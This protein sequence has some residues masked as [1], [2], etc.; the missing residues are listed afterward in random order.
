LF[1]ISKAIEGVAEVRID[2]AD[3]DLNVMD[4][5]AVAE[6]E[7]VIETLAADDTVRA[8]LVTSAKKTFVAGGDLR[9]I[10]AAESLEAARALVERN[11]ACLRR[12][13]TMGKP[14]IALINGLALG[15]GL[16]LAL[17]CTYRIAADSP[18]VKL[19]LPEVGL[20]LMPGA[21]GTVKPAYLIG[22][23][24]AVKLALGGRPIPAREALALGL[25]DEVA[26]A[27]ELVAAALAALDKGTVPSTQPWD[28]QAFDGVLPDPE[29]E[30]GRAVLGKFL[31]AVTGRAAQN[32]P[33]PAAIVAAM[34]EGL[35]TDMDAALL[36][37]QDHFARIVVGP[38]AKA[39][40]RTT[41]FGVNAAKS[42]SMRPRG[43]PAYAIKR[44]GVLGAGQMGA[45]I[46]HVS[47]QARF[48]VAL[49]DISV[50]AAEKGKA[51]IARNCENAVSKGR[52]SRDAAD[53]LLAR[54]TPVTDYDAL[55]GADIIVE[56]VSE[57]EKVKHKVLAMAAEK[58]RPGAPLASNTSTLPITGLAAASPRPEDVIGLHFFAPVDRMPFVEVIRGD[59]TSDQTLARA[60]D[61]IKALRKAV[62]VVRDTLGFYTSRVVAAYTGEAMTLLAEG[63]DPALVDKTALAAGMPLGPLTMCDITSLTLLQDLF[64]SV[65]GDGTRAGVQGLRAKEA[66]ARLVNDFG[67][68]GRASGAGIYDY[69]EGKLTP[70]PG[71]AEAF[72][73]REPPLTP[74]VIE[75]RLMYAQSL[76][77]ARL[78]EQGIVAT[79]T[80]A[81]VGSILGW[82][83]PS[84]TGG[85]ASYIDMVGA[86]KFVADCEALEAEFGG[87]FAVPQ[88]VRDAAASGARFN[89]A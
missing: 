72:P 86:A 58:L 20:G 27:G 18:A 74:E 65:S 80:D 30:S 64:G 83:F 23:E 54:I 9:E 87:R 41:H 62:I 6:L 51:S 71:L 38:V 73:P 32:E 1:S 45:G 49:L 61:Y 52:M 4:Q 34:R 14:V 13:E 37:E 36:I 44:V 5:A 11:R 28:R 33:A 47:A 85:V 67:R 31:R 21:G 16:E 19:G 78:I 57:N 42:M 56:A 75:Q 63:V 22:T 40:I 2:R 60:L 8:V 77:A 81:D 7:Q 50:E 55:D 39:K 84:W 48:E 69:P 82:A 26:P 79:P 29:T 53:A 66:I 10:L 24:E 68:K 70:W 76:E 35:A 15:G 89:A 17:A 43:I 46:A 12:L 59:Q 3:M 88:I 25:I